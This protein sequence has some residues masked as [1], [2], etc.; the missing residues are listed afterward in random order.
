MKTKTKLPIALLGICLSLYGCKTSKQIIEVPVC[1]HDTIRTVQLQHDSVYID[2]WHIQWQSGD[3]IFIY[4]SV[5]RWR[6]LIKIDT[7]YRYVEIPIEV[8]KTIEKEKELSALQRFQIFSGVIFHIIIII[9]VLA[10]SV[11]CFKNRKTS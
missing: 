9:V 5:D 7:A 1:V 2:N 10:F 6:S 11:Y 8:T 3:T 4:D